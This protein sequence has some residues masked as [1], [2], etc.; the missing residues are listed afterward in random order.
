M[1]RIAVGLF[2][3][4]LLSGFAPEASAQWY[5]NGSLHRANGAE[6]K[7]ATS[8]NR[9]ATAADFAVTTLGKAR[10]KSMGSMDRLKPYAQEMSSCLD[11][12]LAGTTGNK[13]QVAEVA[14]ACAVLMGW[15][16]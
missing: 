2:L 5:A 9:L 10:V 15:V 11:E 12:A 14:A 1:R 16:R 7:A 8:A 3:S 13:M 4:V 6:W